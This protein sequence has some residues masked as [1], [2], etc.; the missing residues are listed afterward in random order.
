MQ[1]NDNE[2]QIEMWDDAS[3]CWYVL[4]QDC[5]DEQDAL[6]RIAAFRVLGSEG[7]Y[8]VVVTKY[9]PAM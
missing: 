9:Y 7:S 2:V 8:R 5:K 1:R 6:E 4:P 3:G